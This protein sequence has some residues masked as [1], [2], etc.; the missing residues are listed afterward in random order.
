MATVAHLKRKRIIFVIG[1]F[2]FGGAERQALLLARHLK[3]DLGAEVEFW[4]IGGAGRFSELLDEHQL[5]W[6]DAPVPLP[7]QPYRSTQLKNLIKFALALRRAGPDVILP[8]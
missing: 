8:F 6:R 4:G 3:H 5:K 2:T 7:W 1:T